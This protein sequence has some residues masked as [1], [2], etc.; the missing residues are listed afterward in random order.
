MS[1]RQDGWLPLTPAQTGVW[2]AQQLN[3]QNTVFNLGEY[4]DISGPVDGDVLE[5]ALRQVIG[6]AQTLRVRFSQLDG[7][8]VQQVVPDDEIGWSLERVDLS[9]EAD[10]RAAALS[11]MT[12]E[13]GRP[14]DPLDDPLF[15]FALFKIAE[16]RYFWFY[17]YH[18][19]QADGFTVVLISQRVPEVYSA[20]VRGL[21]SPASPFGPLGQLIAENAA[22]GGSERQAGD[23]EFWLERMADCPEPV[24]LSGRQPGAALDLIHR[25]ARLTR[26]ETDA[27]RSL[28]REAGV[29]WPPVLVAVVAAYLRQLTGEED[30]VLGFP[31]SNRQSALARTT[32]GM[33]SN[34]LPL[35]LAV[36][37][38]TTVSELL[39]Q[40][41][42]AMRALTKHQRYPYEDLRQ[43]LGLFTEGR[44][45]VGSHVNI[46]MVESELAFG[47]HTARP[48]TLS[49]GPTDDL[50]FLVYQR[51]VGEGL[52][53]DCDANPELY[54]T[55]DLAAYH[56]GFLEYLRELAAT[57]PDRRL[58]TIP[59]PARARQARDRALAA[60]TAATVAAGRPAATAPTVDQVDTT[61]RRAPRTPQEEVLC[62]LFAEVLDLDEVGVDDNFFLL[63]GRS[64]QVTRLVSRIRSVL[65]AELGLRTV[66][67]N[68]TVA[69]LAE[70]LGGAHGARQA[71]RPAERPEHLPLSAAQNRLWFLNQ[72]QHDGAVYNDGV[73]IRL[74]GRLD[75]AALRDALG[76]VVA[77]HESL[78]T[79]FPS[80]NGQPQQLVLDP[81]AARP[82]L[83]EIP[84]DPAELSAALA[85]GGRQGFDLVSELPLRARLFRLSEQEHVFQL[86]VHHIACDGW[87]V[88]PFTRDLSAAYGARCAGT[89]PQWQPLPVQYA[90]YVLWQREVLGSTADPASE[91]TRQLRYWQAA[92]DELPEEIAL[93]TDRPRPMTPSY[94]GGRVPFS[95]PS[96]THDRLR[97][98][99]AESHASMFM[100]AQAGLAA[101]LSSMGAGTDIPIGSVIA[102][103]TDEALHDLVGF[104]VNSVVLRTDVSGR[105]TFRQLLARVREADLSAYANQDLPFEQL[106][107]ELNPVRSL[108]RHPL[109]QVALDVQDNARPAL[110]LPGLTAESEM[111]DT[112]TAKFDLMLRLSEQ[113][114]ADG[115][116]AGIRGSLD[117]ATDLFDE[118][119]VQDLVTRLVRI[120][121]A[122]AAEPD[123]PV[124]SVETLSPAERRKLLVEW[125]DTALALP[126]ATVAELFR[127]RVA[128]VPDNTAVVLGEVSLSYRELDERAERLAR[129]LRGHGAGP[130]RIVAALLPRS[131]DLIV[132]FLA[133]QKAGA[134]Y[135]PVDPG[136]PADRISYILGDARPVL[137][138]T[139]TEAEASIPGPVADGPS[140]LLLDRLPTG[141]TDP[142]VPTRSP[143]VSEAAYVIYTSG[144]TGRPKG[145]VVTHAGVAGLVAAQ[146][147]RF[148]I[149]P[150]SRILQFASPSFDASISEICTA[151]LTGAALVL[152]TPGELAAGRPLSTLLAGQRVT[153]ATLPPVLVAALDT[154]ALP[155]RMTLVTAGEACPADLVTRWAPGRRMINA[156]GPTE[157]TVCT[158]MSSPLAPGTGVPPIGRP[159][160]NIRVYVLDD[161]LRPV[162]PGVPGELYIAGGGLA[163]G[164]LHRPGLTAERFVACPFDEPGER[165]YRSGDLVRWNREGELEY[166]HRVDDQVKIRGFRIELGE[167][168]A[169]V[170]RSEQVARA[171]V[172]VREDQPGDKRLVA[173]V[174]P[175]PGGEPDPAEVRG[176]VAAALPDHM[177][178][179]A[180]MVLDAIPTTANGK[181]DRRALPAPDFA[182]DATERTAR[183]P[184][185][186]LLSGL[187]A[188]VL[189]LTRVGI[190]RSFFDLGGHSLLATRLV[191][192]IRS[193]LGAE[194]TVADVFTAPSVAALAQRLA[195][196]GTAR[197][198]LTVMPRPTRIPLSPA[199]QRLWFVNRFQEAGGNY[200]TGLSLSLSGPVDQAALRA[201]LG[202]VLARHES[203]RTVF[204]D[205]DG[206]PS[207]LVLSPEQAGFELTVT[208]I[209]AKERDAAVSRAASSSYDLAVDPPLRAWLFQ[210]GPEEFVLLLVVHHIAG[211]GWSMAPL[212]RDLSVAYRARRAGTAPDW[213]PLP[214]QY[215]DYTLWQR[216][217][218]GDRN[219]PG[220]QLA[221][222]L[223]HW[224]KALAELPEEL[225][226]PTDRPRPGQLSYRGETVEVR[227][228]PDLHDAVARLARSTGSSVFMVVQAAVAA[229][230]GKLGAGEDIP[231]GS[232]IAGRTDE[233]LDDLV[234]FFVNT[235]VLRTDLSG[236]P[237]FRQLV[238]RVRETALAA[239][240]HQDLPFEQLVEELNPARSRARHPL[241]QVML[242]MQNTPQGR[243]DLDGVSVCP[244]PLEI[245]TAKFDLSFQLG[246]LFDQH[247]APAGIEGGIEFATDLF[248]RGTIEELARR[249]ERVL[250]AVT[251]DPDRSLGTVDVLGPA[252]RER[253][254]TEWSATGHG[255]RTGT[256]TELFEAR[257][258]STPGA[259]A[260]VCG[261][262]A[263]SYG[264]V[265]AR[266]NRL[267]RF[268]VARGAGPDRLVGL[269]LPR[270]EQLVVAL[271]A[272]LKAGAGYLPVDPDYPAERITYMFREARPAVVL[273]TAEAAASLGPA[274]T[275]DVPLLVLGSPD[276]DLS[277]LADGD[278]TDDERGGGLTPGNLAY[279]MYTSGSTG[280][281]KGV[282]ITHADVVALA[283]DSRYAEGHEA[284]LLHSAQAFDAS[285]YELWVPLLS[286]GRVV[287][288]P[289]GDLTTV[290]LRETVGRHGVR[291]VWLTAALFRLFAEED[292]GCLSGLREVW[293]GGDVVPAEAVRRVLDTCPGLVVVDGYG[294]TETTTFATSFRMESAQRVP[295]SVPIGRPMDSMRLRV[296]DA[297]LRP[298]P[299]G[300]PGELYV[301]GVGLARG[302]LRRPDLT[303]D[304]FV[305]DPFGD[306]GERMY[307]TGDL[308]RWT[309]DGQVQFMGRA[310]EQVKIR[311]FR[312]EL[313]EIEAAVGSHAGVAQV[314]VVVREDQP[315][316]KRLV[317]YLVAATGGVDVDDVRALV[318]GSLPDHMVPAAFV[319]LDRLPLTANGKLDR[320]ALPAPDFSG[321]TGGRAPRTDR[322][323]L[324]CA[325]FAEVLGLDRIGIDDNFFALGGDSIMSIQLVSRAHKAGLVLRTGDVFQHQTVAALAPVA[326]AVTRRV[327]EDPDAGIGPVPLTPVMHWL[328]EA[329][330]PVDGFNQALLVQAPADCSSERLVRTLQALLERHD[331][332]RLHLTPLADGAW[333]L[334]TL[335]RGSVRAED[336]LRRVDLASADIP[337]E[338]RAAQRRLAPEA[339]TMLQAVWFDAG[340][341]T[342]GR[343]LLMLHHLVVDGVSWRI[344]LEELARQYA[345]DDRE[346]DHGPV[347]TSFRRWA[348]HLVTAARE[349]RRLAELP[350]WTDILDAPRPTLGSRELD[351]RRDTL[352]TSRQLTL[353]L[354]AE[355]TEP[356]L[357]A[358][359][360]AFH[361]GVND[362]LLTA[363]SL[364]VLDWQ[365]RQASGQGV[366]LDLEGHGREEIA[367][368]LD[369]SRTV[370]WFTSLYPVRLDPRVDAADWPEVWA[371]GPA[372]GRALKE[373]KE[374]LRAIP[375]HGLG[376]GL[377]RYLNE[378]TG[379]ALAALPSPRI[380]F[381]YL[382]RIDAA[383]GARGTA[384]WT[385]L[386]GTDLGN[387][388]DPEMPFR[389]ALDLNAV[390]QDHADGPRLVAVWSWPRE[391]FGEEEV[392]ALAETWFRALTAL[393]DHGAGPAAGGFTPSDLPLVNLSQQD[394]DLLQEE[395]GF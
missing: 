324:L 233:A 392:R 21:P 332:L 61:A 198:A 154:D 351:T 56:D 82:A 249:L 395:W 41:S 127:A 250:E 90:D 102:G 297:S 161:A 124:D 359:P 241:F 199:Q 306:P 76:D 68:A 177:V 327:E 71:L 276:V 35:R 168:E 266:A 319:T 185:E 11:R 158:T 370:G 123:A 145:V 275:T 317:A 99:A 85:E 216:E 132:S 104:F 122:V 347:G 18:H 147:E 339:G 100:V 301:A 114:G 345:A 182:A 157:S 373:V 366:L 187:F 125:N 283:T 156:Y 218:L 271:L 270:S 367:E 79:V 304:R 78:R 3:P 315:G 67:E 142:A 13:L 4:L 64:L 308:V 17:R 189:G 183:S 280:M 81:A 214:V 42:R 268:L 376:Y 92:L 262:T 258:T 39:V 164:Y 113:E 384:D 15:H 372:L 33:V 110:T 212:S 273:S 380:G 293:T 7:A 259:I 246:E 150:D 256:L 235:L 106:V 369:V 312:V 238:E 139:S 287:V 84:M 205:L 73:A 165:M 263:L 286:G 160:A 378:H 107:E 37:P 117:Y 204:P 48:C 118:T 16:D 254:L 200:N 149:H 302:Y 209:T 26:Q 98:L 225:A 311:G 167:I 354:P 382:G 267:A 321:T 364:A 86:V 291:A 144:S 8:P 335:P 109:F 277:G 215:A 375:D 314:A 208:Q 188:E 44:R 236:N 180:V 40:T 63:G 192:R 30:V 162:P 300:V 151:V 248:D 305:A 93:P 292:P 222:Q 181:L 57:D 325:L 137:V 201:A 128:E 89:A 232:V 140:R 152:A 88:A 32:P 22:Y 379:P 77:R 231:I 47:D 131:V 331:A 365:G 264:E 55:T 197:R 360:A 265:N 237:S 179:A 133:V 368:D 184:Q 27:L 239:Y 38:D 174:V 278:L 72:L 362:V 108:A 202:D 295:Q 393:V 25:T 170:A 75:A 111:L 54:D 46:A 294:P 105:P 340:P 282:V 320:R 322:E 211:D 394:L 97:A 2:F 1:D 217:V 62:G 244:L 31:V 388:F 10:P 353:T 371:G 357:T 307:R 146:Q 253:I 309:A 242:T 289:A 101:L 228:R 103:R 352:A 374:Q 143:Q 343:L 52:Q 230:L 328:R 70:H 316:V 284:V 190:D 341:G 226:L 166:L 337:A 383:E 219:D 138:L 350:L 330:G 207:Q 135:L 126:R 65:R 49:T 298:V 326:E 53:I 136:Y 36:R 285:T 288:A 14:V 310:D 247:D 130:E 29:S 261:E 220:S 386:P 74:T 279:V 196:A 119:T 356:L 112:E 210:L 83:P 45:M 115:E 255:T 203:L 296:L 51:H 363:F 23:R 69:T 251:A 6:E 95:L 333:A 173:Y 206:Q 243:L 227:I 223:D 134:V 240:A 318:S 24:S 169:V 390:V 120:L 91:L 299:A 342:A 28:G 87:S 234:G 385:A 116:P 121:E 213:E 66:F 377:L 43:D 344:L 193:E 349:P 20:L 224:R 176:A 186:E 389:H 178:P 346:V 334:E 9:Q 153:H 252:E 195:A 194:L 5:A 272:V 50:S 338:A 281:P 191:S 358:V 269:A 229:L 60:L 59:V 361:A 245:D 155:P 159:I 175:T 290:T 336:L 391:L 323:E 163:R 129:L 303:A 381:N 34:V 313:G 260:V 148:D 171:V 221:G 387:G 329:D 274:L 257:A 12:E 58:D 348:E 355:R 172:V 80:E 96:P 94:R 141:D 19:L